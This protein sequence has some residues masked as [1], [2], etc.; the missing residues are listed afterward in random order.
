MLR[1][2]RVLLQTI[3]SSVRSRSQLLLEIA[4][5]RQQLAVYK[6]RGRRPRLR[7]ADRPFWVALRRFWSRWTDA[8]TFVKPETVIRWHRKGFRLYWSWIS[9]RRRRPGRPRVT[10]G[11]RA[12]IRRMADE[13]N[14]GAPRIHASCSSSASMFQNGQCCDTSKGCDDDLRQGRVG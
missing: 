3:S 4:A 1:L 11:I 12:L 8:L 5:L 6:A 2:L 7:A 14:W 10:A 9:R 13:N